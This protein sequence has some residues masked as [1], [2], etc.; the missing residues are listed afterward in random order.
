M[1]RATNIVKNKGIAFDGSGSWS[2]G[3]DFARNIKIFGA[4]NS[5]SCHTDNRKSNFSLLDGSFGRSNGTSINLS[6]ANTKFCLSLHY[7]DD[8]SYLFV[9]GKEIYKF[10]TNNKNVNSQTQF[11][12]GSISRWFGDF[13][14]REVSLRANMYYFS[15]DYNAI[16]KSDILNIQKYLMK[17]NNIK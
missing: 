10:K 11:C 8:N 16:G 1:F 3:N 17:E 14:S 4:D 15:V 13:D 6:K 7:N 2:F 9:N 5:L 12:L